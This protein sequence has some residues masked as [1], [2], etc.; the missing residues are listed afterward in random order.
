MLIHSIVFNKTS[1]DMHNDF[2][3]EFDVRPIFW[4]IRVYITQE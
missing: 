3:E 1:S 4:E 2:V